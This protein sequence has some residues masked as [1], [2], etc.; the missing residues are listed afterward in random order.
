MK[1][2]GWEWGGGKERKGKEKLNQTTQVEFELKLPV[3]NIHFF[4]PFFI[5]L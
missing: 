5:F 3:L 1:Q 2:W 4:N